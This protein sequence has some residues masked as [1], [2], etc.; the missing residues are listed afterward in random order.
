MK[1]PHSRVP[2]IPLANVQS[3][4]AYDTRMTYGCL[5]ISPLCVYTCKHRGTSVRH[6]PT[7]VLLQHDRVTVRKRF[8]YILNED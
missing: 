6:H 2:S 5:I 4:K 7:V 1:R 3:T 8:P